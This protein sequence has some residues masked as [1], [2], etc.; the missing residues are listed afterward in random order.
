MNG[1]EVNGM[2]VS[3][4]ISTSPS[5]TPKKALLRS[6]FFIYKGFFDPAGVM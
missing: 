5:A 3:P 2:T 6:A 4:L 1:Y